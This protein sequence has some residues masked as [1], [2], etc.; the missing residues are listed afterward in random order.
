[1]ASN[2]QNVLKPSLQDSRPGARLSRWMRA[3]GGTVLANERSAADWPLLLRLNDKHKEKHGDELGECVD[4]PE[5][6]CEPNICDDFNVC[7]T[8]VC[9]EEGDTCSNN[10]DEGAACGTSGTCDAGGL[11]VEPEL[12]CGD[13]IVNGSEECDDGNQ[14]DT[15]VCT[16]A[17]ENPVCGDTITS[18][19]EQCDDGANNGTP[20]FC[21]ATCDGTEPAVCGDGIVTPPETCDNENIGCVSCQLPTGSGP[22]LLFECVCGTHPM[23]NLVVPVNICVE[24]IDTTLACEQICQDAFGQPFL[25]DDGLD[26]AAS[27]LGD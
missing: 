13:G 14:V 22:D 2:D 23:D 15:D 6:F 27:C 17:C 18:P 25:F 20:G 8:D 26:N 9:D 10:V 11:C 3:N 21:N 1:M 19:P 12:F 4:E 16:N 5:P 24:D 7:T